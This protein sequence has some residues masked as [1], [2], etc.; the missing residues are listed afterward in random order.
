MSNIVDLAK[1]AD[2]EIK[3]LKAPVNAFTLQKALQKALKP[4][5]EAL[6]KIREE[7]QEALLSQEEES[8]S[9]EE[10]EVP[11]KED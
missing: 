5:Q 2:K 8:F 9:E 1:E 7:L 3:E 11:G 6:Q 10:R 4:V